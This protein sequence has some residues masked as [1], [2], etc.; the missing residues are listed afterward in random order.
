MNRGNPMS[1]WVLIV[2]LVMPGVSLAEGIEAATY[3][4]QAAC[5]EQRDRVA[6]QNGISFVAICVKR[7]K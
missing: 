1:E 5:E 6:T 4:T 2:W 7:D 3:R